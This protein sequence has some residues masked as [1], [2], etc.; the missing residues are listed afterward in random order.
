MVWA[1]YRD[2]RSVDGKPVRDRAA[3]LEALFPP[4]WTP[5]AR[6]R[7]QEI[8]AESSRYNV[9]TRRTVNSPTLALACLHPRNQAR[10]AFRVAGADT[11]AGVACWKLRLRERVEPTLV[12]TSRGEDVP[13]G[14]VLWVEAGRGTVLATEAEMRAPRAGAVLIETEYRLHERL[15]SWLPSEMREAYGNR[16]RGVGQDRVEARATYTGW[17]RAAAQVED[18]ILPPAVKP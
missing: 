11:K 2:V 3:R 7:A 4:G 13:L 14:G 17:R 9:G 6:D 12:R 18:I 16:V 1:F 5:E 8:L 10:F 15:G